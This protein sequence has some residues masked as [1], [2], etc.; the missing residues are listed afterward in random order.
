MIL[1]AEAEGTQ[2]SHQL[3]GHCPERNS[4][5]H[6]S[7]SRHRDTEILVVQIHAESWLELPGNHRCRLAVEDAI[8]RKAGCEDA[9]S[10]VGINPAGFHQ[11]NGFSDQLDGSGDY[12]LIGCFHY[13]TRTSWAN[14]NNR[15]SEHIEHRCCSVKSTR[16]PA[17]HDRQRSF[18]SA[19]LTAGYWRVENSDSPFCP[20]LREEAGRRGA[21]R[22]HINED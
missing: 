22:A 11:N 12:E 9:N 2:R 14:V 8:T 10:R 18:D 13:L 17:Y 20:C 16:L 15:A 4:H 21:N 1:R 6:L 7:R 5:T 19:L 3:G